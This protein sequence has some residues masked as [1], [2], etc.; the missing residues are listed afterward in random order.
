MN[1]RLIST[2]LGPCFRL[3]LL[4]LSL[5]NQCSFARNPDG[6]REKF[7]FQVELDASLEEDY[8][9]EDY[10]NHDHNDHNEEE[11]EEEGKLDG[12]LVVK[13]Y[14]PSL[15]QFLTDEVYDQHNYNLDGIEDVRIKPS[16]LHDPSF[17][18]TNDL[19]PFSRYAN[20]HRIVLWYSPY[21]A[22]CQ[23]FKS[24]YIELAEDL[25]KMILHHNDSS[26][27]T[28]SNDNMNI[29]F[30]AISCSAHHWLC[31]EYEI[32]GFP[33]LWVYKAN[34]NHYQILEDYTVE[35]LAKILDFHYIPQSND[36]TENVHINSS[37]REVGNNS[38]EQNVSQNRNDEVQVQTKSTSTSRINTRRGIPDAPHSS[39]F[40]KIE[41]D[42]STA[43]TD[44][45]IDILGASNDIHKRTRNDIFHDAAMSFMHSITSMETI[46]SNSAFS[47]SSIEVKPTSTFFGS[48][49][50]QSKSQIIRGREETLSEYLDLL[51][52]SAPPSWK[53]LTIISEIRFSLQEY[54][55][56]L[57]SLSTESLSEKE[58]M[59]IMSNSIDSHQNFVLENSP[60][61]WTQ[62]CSSSSSSTN[63]RTEKFKKGR[64]SYQCGL[65][66][67]FHIMSIGVAERHKAVV[68]GRDR[69]STEHAALTLKHFISNYILHYDEQVVDDG[70]TKSS[71]IHNKQQHENEYWKRLLTLLKRDCGL[72]FESCDRFHRPR[73]QQKSHHYYSDTQHWR[74]FSLWLWGIHNEMNVMTY[75]DEM[76]EN[77]RDCCTKSQESRVS[78]PS[79][80]DCPGCRNVNGDWNKEKVYEFLKS[81][82]WPS[83][84]HNFRYVV[85]DVKDQHADIDSPSWT[86]SIYL[87]KII[88]FSFII[89]IGWKKILTK[90]NHFKSIGL[91]KKCD[92]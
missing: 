68:G 81:Q 46:T 14:N 30:H 78:Y 11:K 49:F 16:F 35:G 26:T 18:R 3:Q 50:F 70:N 21:C 91:Q 74:E 15:H 4:L 2:I 19:S 87:P 37:S 75:Q 84:I 77:G 67:L 9:Y 60:P 76:K 82:Y 27:S 41:K 51:F 45:V 31:E 6:N 73:G 1:S 39:T 83:G 25:T 29:E 47:S 69:V 32:R 34:S 8:F 7:L 28:S 85:L 72:K 66:N 59:M 88:F 65:W 52:W 71:S 61:T 63:Q 13:E 38:N 17:E 57:S 55:S 90:R 43:S 5:Q 20:T 33:L 79:Q 12:T 24:T 56:S 22:H 80:R 62:S 36:Q 86:I 53:L 48:V 42:E 40:D 58:L 89:Y 44:K 64:S 23:R 54:Q 92:D 10:Y